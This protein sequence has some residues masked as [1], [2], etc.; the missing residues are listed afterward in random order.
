M[1]HPNLFMKP[2]WLVCLA[3]VP[4]ATS[5]AQPLVDPTRPPAHLLP[6]VSG[7]AAPPTTASGTGLQL[8]ISSP[9]RQL[10]LVD[11]QLIQRGQTHDAGT[12]L[13]TRGHEAVL[14]KDGERVSLSMHPLVQKTMRPLPQPAKN[15]TT[16]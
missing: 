7:A 8:V 10:A 15:V 4:C 14:R 16:R 1:R 11:G 12:L 6:A 2:H 3:A 9:Q 13:H 5:L